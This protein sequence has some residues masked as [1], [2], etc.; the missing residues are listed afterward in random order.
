MNDNM[1]NTTNLSLQILR[2]GCCLF[3]CLNHCSFF[4]R[5]S[6][7]E[8]GVEFFIIL[9]GLLSALN[10]DKHNHLRRSYFIDKIKKLCPL[11][12]IITLFVFAVGMFVPQLFSSMVFDGKTLIAS[13]LFIPGNT[14]ILYPGW[15]LTY[16]L[17][18]YLIYFIADKL[19]NKRDLNASIIIVVLVIV[20]AILDICFSGNV[21]SKYAN[22]IMLEFVYGIALY[23][24]LNKVKLKN[25]NISIFV[26][27]VLTV[28]VFF[29]YNK[30]LGLRWI[31]PSLIVCIIIACVYGYT[32]TGK[33][34]KLL[35]SIGNISFTI[36]I[37]HPV[38]IRP[39]DKIIIKIIGSDCYPIYFVG[40]IAIVVITVII[41]YGVNKIFRKIHL[42]Y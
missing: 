12:W 36:Y 3:I 21:F 7:G 14:F 39:L 35:A 1:T 27:V 38:I 29:N 4:N 17:E 5:Y 8:I 26:A 11:Y 16:F 40:V 34:A 24:I 30:Y 18:F 31:V 15:T 23:H 33:T 41:C 10:A 9:S 19:F 42:V 6:F 28:L 13:L 22:P 2:G 32:F 37:L 25:N 20:G